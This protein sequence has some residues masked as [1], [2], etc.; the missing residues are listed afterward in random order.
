MRHMF[1]G[2]IATKTIRAL[3][4]SSFLLAATVSAAAFAEQAGTP[5]TEQ[6]APAMPALP[7]IA[8]ATETLPESSTLS[9]NYLAGRFA[10]GQQDW[11]AAQSYMN[12]VIAFDDQNGLLEQRA[13]L[14]SV[15]ARRYDQ[16]KELA[17]KVY[18]DH[19]NADLAMIYLASD[20][21]AHDKYKD[22]LE[23]VRQL[24]DDGF[25][26]Y[27][28]PLLT[29]WCYM[30]MGDKAKAMALLKKDAI[31][32]DPTYH[33]HA[34]LMEELSG[35]M[36]GAEAHYRKAMEDGLTLNSAVMSANFFQ[37]QHQPEIAQ[38]IYDGIGKLYPS[39]PFVNALKVNGATNITHA[40][41]G[42][43]VALFDL[44]TLLY[45]RR[46]YDSAQIYGSMAL[47]MAPK[48]P[49]ATMMLGDIA[50]LHNQFDKGI[51]FYNSI[52]LDSPLYWMAQLRIGEVY[53][54]SGRLDDAVAQLQ[55]LSKDQRL[56]V[57]ALVSLG[58]LYR[59]HDQF[60]NAL[61]SYDDALAA[62]PVTAAQWPVIYAR[63]MAQ[64]RLNHWQ[65]A[66]KDLLKALEFQPDN[67]MILNFI[68]YSWADKGV[69]L[70]KALGYIRRAVAMRPD[71]GYMVDSLGWALY[72]TGNYP[73]SVKWMEKAVGIIPD[74]PTILDHLGDAY[75]QAGRHN[76]AV[77]KWKRA[78]EL[79]KDADFRSTVEHKMA[80]GVDSAPQVAQHKEANLQ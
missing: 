29:A 57:S 15:G 49:F 12:S 59:R 22:A 32:T 73:E 4:L 1:T 56:H 51:A 2:L 74:D 54:I 71:D 40:A 7:P 65:M 76:E 75:W 43:A 27:T 13:F 62:A 30:G 28:K 36:K 8:V 67:P 78:H 52:A 23:Y 34:A 25:G 16:A 63:G 11:D 60:E 55:E 31:D 66:E 45:E 21:M 70:D 79:S 69:H 37:R 19:E 42:A 35:N 68:G 46:A 72:R 41:D 24:P 6:A 5:S 47:L 39:N 38:N 3:G 33:V 50:A 26:Q 9:G 17:D 58:D 44:A 53:E 14:L 18:S 80:R 10:Q 77:F 64:E 48:M 61:H 20:A